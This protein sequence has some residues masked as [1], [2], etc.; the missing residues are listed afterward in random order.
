[1]ILPSSRFTG[2][3][4]RC[5]P[6]QLELNPGPDAKQA[7]LSLSPALHYSENSLM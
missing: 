6:V 2:V 4:H 7:P 5:I 3:Y 1:M